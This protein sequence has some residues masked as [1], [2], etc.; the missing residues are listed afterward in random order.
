MTCAC[1]FSTDD[2]RAAMQP[3]A[4]CDKFLIK[5]KKLRRSNKRAAGNDYQ[6]PRVGKS[7]GNLTARRETTA[8]TQSKGKHEQKTN[9]RRA[10]IEQECRAVLLLGGFSPRVEELRKCWFM[11]VPIPSGVSTKSEI[12]SGATLLTLAFQS[13]PACWAWR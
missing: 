1:T 7:E 13:T 10:Q 12:I 8:G 4:R 11:V 3:V 2:L 9:A 5:L 6:P